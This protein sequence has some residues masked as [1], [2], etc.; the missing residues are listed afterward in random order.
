[1]VFYAVDGGEIGEPQLSQF[2]TK[3]GGEKLDKSIRIFDESAGGFC[4]K[5][6][7]YL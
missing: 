3:M 2:K 5:F 4:H 1:V 6:S 7:M